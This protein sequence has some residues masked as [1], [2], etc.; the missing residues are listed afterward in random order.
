MGQ[1]NAV[2]AQA[3]GAV[4]ANGNVG[5]ACAPNAYTLI[6]MGINQWVIASAATLFVYIVEDP[7]HF[8]QQTPQLVPQNVPGFVPPV[9]S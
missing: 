5:V 1:T 9:S 8:T 2:A 4:D 6:S 7:T 3:I